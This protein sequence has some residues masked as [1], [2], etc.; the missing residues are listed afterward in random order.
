SET[1]DRVAS[2]VALHGL[3]FGVKCG[4]IDAPPARSGRIGNPERRPGK[5]VGPEHVV[6]SDPGILLGDLNVDWESGTRTK[7]SIKRPTPQERT[8]SWNFVSESGGECMPNVK[9]GRC[10]IAA[11]RQAGA[12]PVEC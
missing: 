12:C 1:L 2:Q 4:G 6:E 7:Q 11:R 5:K 9:I 10:T 8:R 3:R